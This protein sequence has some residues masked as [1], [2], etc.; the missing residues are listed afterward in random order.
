MS[1]RTTSSQESLMNGANTP[2]RP[3][4]AAIRFLHGARSFAITGV[5]V[6]LLIG[7]CSTQSE[8]VQRGERRPGQYVTWASADKARCEA[9]T[10]LVNRLPNE[11]IA[12]A[13]MSHIPGFPRW[14]PE[15]RID[16]E[17]SAGGSPYIYRLDY[18]YLDPDGTGVEKFIMRW[19]GSLSNLDTQSLYVLSALP[20]TRE[21]VRE[22][23]SRP[24]A[25]TASSTDYI[26]QLRRMH[27]DAWKD[28]F[29]RD[30]VLVSAYGERQPMF[31]ASET[32][33]D[34][35]VSTRT[36]V[37]M[38]DHKG[39]RQDICMLRRVCGCYESCTAPFNTTRERSE[40]IP[41]ASFCNQR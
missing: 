3:P 2:E 38:L 13:S 39:N 11:D 37:F 18:L 19:T 24:P 5:A 29:I 40:L 7:A 17:L 26:S 4:S 14:Q 31:F 41:T 9:A 8:P 1:L 35:R 16:Q 21:E 30:Q 27:G 28:W 36:I 12:K 22:I 32:V 23:I 25:F 10:G 20:R 15:P 34:K 33:H 6:T